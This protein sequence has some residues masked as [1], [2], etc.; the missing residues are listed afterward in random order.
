M[1]TQGVG[2]QRLAD[3]RV[4]E[5][6][7]HRD[8]GPVA[9]MPPYRREHLNRD[10]VGTIEHCRQVTDHATGPVGQSQLDRPVQILDD[11]AEPTGNL[12]DH[13]LPY[14]AFLDPYLPTC[15]QRRGGLRW[16]LAPDVGGVLSG[17]P[18]REEDHVVVEICVKVVRTSRLLRHG[19]L[20]SVIPG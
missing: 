8:P 4:R 12:K 1:T 6:Y 3:Q 10:G 14:G 18:G 16:E 9:N 5:G 7:G 13:Y 2:G 19:G 20:D 17:K 11:I 15:G